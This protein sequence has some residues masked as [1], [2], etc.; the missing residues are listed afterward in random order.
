MA[1]RK[2]PK[3]SDRKISKFLAA[4]RKLTEAVEQD[5]SPE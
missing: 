2:E 1:K 4:Y 3:I 5:D